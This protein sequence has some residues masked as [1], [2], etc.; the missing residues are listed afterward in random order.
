M[1]LTEKAAEMPEWILITPMPL[2]TGAATVVTSAVLPTLRRE[3]GAGAFFVG[4]SLSVSLVVAMSAFIVLGALPRAVGKR[5][6][7]LA[8]AVAMILGCVVLATAKN[9]MGFLIGVALLI[10]GTRLVMMVNTGGVAD[11]RD[12]H[13]SAVLSRS[14][15]SYSAGASACCIAAALLLMLKGGWRGTFVIVAATSLLVVSMV[16]FSR[17]VEGASRSRNEGSMWKMAN[18]RRHPISFLALAAA[19]FL[20]CAMTFSTWLTSYFASRD[21]GGASSAAAGMALYCM[22]FLMGVVLKRLIGATLPDAAIV[23]SALGLGLAGLGVFFLFDDPVLA[24]L[25][26]LVVAMAFGGA[27][28]FLI[29]IVAD[30]EPADPWEISAIF[31]VAVLLAGILAQPASGLV[32]DNFGERSGILVPI[33]GLAAALV[34]AL[35]LRDRL[36]VRSGLLVEHDQLREPTDGVSRHTN[37]IRSGRS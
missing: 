6:T 28:V 32:I 22:A 11:L 18:P 29:A 16:V 1:E 4:C 31:H 36:G 23:V 27:Q 7:F 5:A 10:P 3:L 25:S 26:A 33:A 14:A 8:S 9:P 35:L 12:C 13:R 17:K 24:L 37:Q 15:I 19:F 21:F 30:F 20:E 34:C 2:S